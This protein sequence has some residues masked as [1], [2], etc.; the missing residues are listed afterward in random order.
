MKK[1]FSFLL[2]VAML[3]SLA[4]CGIPKSAQSTSSTDDSASSVFD[5]ITKYTEDTSEPT[6]GEDAKT[7]QDLTESVPSSEVTGIRPEF[8]EAM[9]SYE[10]FYTK[11]C[12]V[13]KAYSKNPTDMNLL[14]EYSDLLGK[15][16][17]V[18]Q[19]FEAW[20]ESEL[21]SEELQ[22]YLDVNSRVIKM[23]SEVGE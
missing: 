6:K 10:A 9:D 12:E 23:L 17:D 13:L 1:V 20:D 4:A 14:S 16:A 8:K 11:Y 15:A 3:L 18:D 21:S 5:S 22:Y 2:T 7:S 19:A